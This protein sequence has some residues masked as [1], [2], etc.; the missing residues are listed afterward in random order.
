MLEEMLVGTEKKPAVL[1]D[2]RNNS[3]NSQ[4]HFT[5]T[6][7]P[8]KMRALSAPA[9]GGLEKSFDLTSNLTT[10]N[11]VCFDRNGK[12]RKYRSAEEILEDFYP[13]RLE[14][15]GKRKAAMERVLEEEWE[16]LSA[17]A[18][19]ILEVV[20]EL[21]VLNRRRKADIVQDLRK[22]GYLAIPPGGRGKRRRGELD[23]A[24][25]QPEAQEGGEEGE[26]GEKNVSRDYDYLLSM[27]LH[28]LTTERVARLERERDAKG[29][30]LDH[31]RAKSPED[32]WEIDLAAFL[33]EWDRKEASFNEAMA[34]DGAQLGDGDKKG[35]KKAGG[36]TRKKATAG[37]KRKAEDG[38][39]ATAKKT[40]MSTT[41]KAE[42]VTRN[43][44]GDEI[45]GK[46]ES[47]KVVRGRKKIVDDEDDFM[48]GEEDDMDVI[49]TGEKRRPSSRRAV[50]KTRYVESDDGEDGDGGDGY[51]DDIVSGDEMMEEEDDY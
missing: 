11:M 20:S 37:V 10:G 36:A 19:F 24:E 22:R 4:V 6:M 12:L 27:P 40:T 30:D 14:Y 50:T 18:R 8:E 16:E 46:P 45:S 21:L 34:N 5:L 13:L 28:S 2:Y 32:L 38:K 26:E 35:K 3:S 42:K 44:D 17:K 23:Q 15:Y 33:E 49:P 41:K 7:T 1:K 48:G 29:L 43:G 47:V 25:D 51:E 31:L 9:S 39:A